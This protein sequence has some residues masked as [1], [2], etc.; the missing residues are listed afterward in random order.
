MST[1][2]GESTRSWHAASRV[3]GRG[4]LVLLLAWSCCCSVLAQDR[5]SFLSIDRKKLKREFDYYNVDLALLPMP[6]EDEPVQGPLPLIGAPFA[7]SGTNEACDPRH[8]KK[9]PTYR[10]LIEQTF[11]DQIPKVRVSRTISVPVLLTREQPQEPFVS[12]HTSGFDTKL[13]SWQI[14]ILHHQTADDTELE[15]AARAIDAVCPN[16]NSESFP[17]IR[18]ILVGVP[19][20]VLP[21]RAGSV[22]DNDSWEP[23]RKL[24]NGGA[25]VQPKRLFVLGV[26]LSN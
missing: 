11:S 18:R 7:S 19:V 6:P 12:I 25:L 4:V 26:G 9:R 21:A 15:I 23:A 13:A 24:E 20:L 17:R 10:H 1:H 8:L 14:V 16:L 5:L 22:A 2:P 3:F